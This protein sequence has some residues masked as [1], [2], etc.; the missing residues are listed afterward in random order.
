MS[1][2]EAYPAPAI[3]ERYDPFDLV[4][5]FPFYIKARNEAP[6]FY[7]PELD[8]WVITRYEDI[9]AV[10]KDLVTFSSEITG[11]PLVPLGP[12]VEK[13]LHDGG[14]GTLSGISSTMPPD[15]TRIR[16]FINKGLSPRRVEKLE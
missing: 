7:S 2:I 6:I 10:F 3:A 4:D 16:S 12:A 14:F 5:P 1:H 11:K 13:V 15:H 9:K 8:Y